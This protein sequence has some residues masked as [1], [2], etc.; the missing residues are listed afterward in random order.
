MSVSG[1]DFALLKFCLEHN[2]SP[3]LHESVF[4]R[5][6]ADYDWLR[7]VMDALPT[8]SKRMEQCLDVIHNNPDEEAKVDALFML[9]DLVED[10]DVANGKWMQVDGWCGVD[11][12]V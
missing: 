4:H 2:D 11:L 10:L 9:Q 7:K 1:I 8:T 12:G 3:N 5:D 6:P